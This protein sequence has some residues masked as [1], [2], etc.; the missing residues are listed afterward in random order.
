MVVLVPGQGV[1][2]NYAAIIEIFIQ[3]LDRERGLGYL[4][5][6]LFISLPA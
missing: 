3:Q 4:D 2:I 6:E 1:R 5:S